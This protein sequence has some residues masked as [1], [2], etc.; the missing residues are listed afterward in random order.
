MVEKLRPLPLL[1]PQRARE[2]GTLPRTKSLSIF[3]KA[4]CASKNFVICDVSWTF[5]NNTIHRSWK[6][7]LIAVSADGCFE[8]W[9]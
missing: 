9:A 5:E 4:L 6:C 8:K 3:L 7:W 2:L 1:I